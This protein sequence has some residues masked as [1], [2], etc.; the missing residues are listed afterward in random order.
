[1]VFAVASAETRSL[2]DH[3]HFFSTALISAKAQSFS[4]FDGSDFDDGTYLAIIFNARVV[5]YLYLL[6]AL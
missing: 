1:M 5:V 2:C 6:Y 4:W 3:V